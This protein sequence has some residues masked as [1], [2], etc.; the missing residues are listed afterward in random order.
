M[1]LRKLISTSFLAVAVCMA[2]SAGAFAN[3]L[4]FGGFAIFQCADL[5]YVAP[6]TAAGAPVSVAFDPNGHPTNVTAV[7]WQIGFGNSLINSGLGA[8][9]TGNSAPKTFNGNDSGIAP[10]D[11]VDAQIATANP[12]IP[13]GAVCLRGSNWG[14]SGFDGCCDNERTTLLNPSNDDILNPYYHVYYY[15]SF[16]ATYYDGFYNL[17]WHQ[18]YPM[19]FLLTLDDPNTPLSAD[20][21][22]FAAVATLNRGNTG[23]NGTCYWAG[24][25]N[26]APCDHRPGN[27][28]FKDVSNGL[29]NAAT[30]LPNVIPWQE[31]PSPQEDSAVPQDPNDVNAPVDLDISW[32]AVTLYSDQ[33]VRPSTNLAMGPADPNF[34]DGVGV[35]DIEAKFPLVRYVVEVAP[36]SDPNFDPNNLADRIECSSAY[37][38][39]SD[40][41]C[42]SAT[43][44]SF[45]IPVAHCIRVRTILGKKSQTTGV[46]VCD[47]GGT[48][49]CTA[50][51]VGTACTQDSDCDF[52]TTIAMCRVGMCGDLGYEVV[53]G[54]DLCYFG[55]RDGDLV[56]DALDNCI[57]TYNPA[58]T[59]DP[60]IPCVPDA[61]TGQCDVDSDG[62]G[63]ACDICVLTSNPGRTPQIDTNDDG[64]INA[65]DCPDRNHETE[66]CDYDMDGVG[67][68]CDNC[69]LTSNPGQADGDA[70]AVG[71]DCDS[72]LLTYNPAGMAQED[73]NGDL[74]VDPNDCLPAFPTDQ[75]DF[76]ADG[77]GDTCD[78]CLLDL[79]PAGAVFDPNLGCVPDPETGQCDFDA[80]VV[81]DHCDNCTEDYN[82]GQ[83]DSDGDGYGD[84]CD[85]CQAG[86]PDLDGYCDDPY[87]PNDINLRFNDNCPGLYNPAQTNT[88]ND[89][90]GDECDP[91]DDN[92]GVPDDGD[93]SG[94]IGDNK[95][96]RPVGA[97]PPGNC[98]DNCRVVANA[99]Q[100][101]DD[102]DRFGNVCDNCRLLYNPAQLDGDGDS[103]GDDCDTCLTTPNPR[104]IPSVDTNG[105]GVINS[106]D[107]TPSP[108]TSQCDYDFD[109][110]GDA[111]DN[112]PLRYNPAGLL[113]E[114]TNLDGFIDPNDQ[115]IPDVETGQCDFDSDGVGGGCDNCPVIYN[116]AGAVFDPNFGCVI[117]LPGS[118][119]CNYDSDTFGDHCDNCNL[120]FGGMGSPNDD[121]DGDRVCDDVDNCLLFYNPSNRDADS[122]AVGD[123]CD[124][125]VRVPNPDQFET[126]GDGLGDGCDNCAT[127]YNPAG[128]AVFPATDPN[129]GQPFMFCVEDPDSDQ[130]DVD[131]DGTG[132]ACDLTIYDP[133]SVGLL[134]SSGTVDCRPG[135]DPPRIRW[136]R[137]FWDRYR[138]QI[139]WDPDFPR[140]KRITSGDALLGRA[141]W[142]PGR[143][144]W[145]EVCRRADPYLY[146]RV[147][148][149]DMQAAKGDPNRRAISETIQVDTIK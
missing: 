149:I 106:A 39:D 135:A 16:G 88:E 110:I 38:T 41:E 71:D 104:L 114:D 78:T 107:C 5:A 30:G 91:D 123:D 77:A 131:S 93:N 53:S 25:T 146:I 137:A 58:G 102:S 80:D 27:Y 46:G 56:P 44:A 62:A 138:V 64:N 142:R 32:P 7:F 101:D 3:C 81:G 98:D 79:N 87:D 113:E 144:K 47:T 68:I 57:E 14:N 148:G 120:G 75:C 89:L 43:S 83:E 12:N 17:D 37:P 112:C 96:T 115:C 29:A 82:P 9:G 59:A 40:P 124:N 31:I 86:D 147:I 133:L 111:C 49:L 24:G 8:Y 99:G 74:V 118:G 48:G 65:L 100:Q 22:A 125:C 109:R 84:P 103:V 139:S 72:C 50:G 132:D 42:T 19:A 33:S 54:G 94:V 69:F 134:P 52:T 6:T 119:Q 21:F 116:P 18:D 1:K 122:D 61:V 35:S 28:L 45:T 73:T 76:D 11:L 105:N 129:T 130:C 127:V 13:A 26:P 36:A 121:A 60:N 34:S 145:R 128:A 51:N 4:E 85:P 20:F 108:F 92:D 126:D 67:D 66:Q 10:L 95:C 141:Y 136:G 140:S 143:K 117:Q 55:D 70:D 97:P 23:G 63:D 90:L 2:A 15:R